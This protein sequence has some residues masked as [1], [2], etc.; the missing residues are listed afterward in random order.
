M[1]EVS[2]ILSAIPSICMIEPER[3][4]PFPYLGHLL[5][6]SRPHL[7]VGAV[8]VALPSWHLGLLVSFNRIY[9][10]KHLDRH[11][12]AFPHWAPFGWC[13]GQLMLSP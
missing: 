4:N 10:V 7:D 13:L 5:L 2:H 6:F 9:A 11:L 1:A 8:S 3:A 12:Q